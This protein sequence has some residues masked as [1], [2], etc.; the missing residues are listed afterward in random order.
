[1]LIGARL[2]IVG[3][4]ACGVMREYA[5]WLQRSDT[6]LTSRRSADA[7]FTGLEW[8]F[9]IGAMRLGAP[10]D[11]FLIR[12]DSLS[13]TTPGRPRRLFLSAFAADSGALHRRPRARLHARDA[14]RDRHGTAAL[15]DDGLA[16]ARRLRAAARH[17][18]TRSTRTRARRDDRPTR[19][20]AWER[21]RGVRNASRRLAR[22]YVRRCVLR[23]RA[24]ARGDSAWILAEGD[25]VRDN[26]AIGFLAARAGLSRES[27]LARIVTSFAARRTACPPVAPASPPSGAVG[28][29]AIS[30]SP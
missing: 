19:R 9:A 12:G 20:R 24:E 21:W 10:R 16:A 29:P 11:F 30:G 13:A 17:R 7:R 27:A 22:A 28:V 3:G 18:R 6:L 5:D 14:R 2:P 4:P 25:P 8:D 15:R 26:D 1:M 23:E